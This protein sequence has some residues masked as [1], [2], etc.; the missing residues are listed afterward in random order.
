MIADK[1]SKSFY[2]VELT[3]SIIDTLIPREEYGIEKIM[4]GANDIGDDLRALNAMQHTFETLINLSEKDASK[5][6]KEVEFNPEFF[7]MVKNEYAEK[8]K[9]AKAQQTL[10]IEDELE[11]GQIAIPMTKEFDPL[12]DFVSSRWTLSSDD[13]KMVGKVGFNPEEYSK[14]KILEAQENANPLI[15]KSAPHLH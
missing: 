6:V 2:I 1:V 14:L 13:F 3:G 8:I 5:I 10:D 12:G 4:M 7:P 15:A 9:I 11:Q